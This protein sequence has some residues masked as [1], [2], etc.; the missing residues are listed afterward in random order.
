M[1]MRLNQVLR[2]AAGSGAL[3]NGW[4]AGVMPVFDVTVTYETSLRKLRVSFGSLQT[5]SFRIAFIGAVHPA[6]GELR[7]IIGLRKIDDTPGV[8]LPTG[9]TYG[10]DAATK[11][12]RWSTLYAQP[13]DQLP[14]AAFKQGVVFPLACD[15]GADVR[16]IQIKTDLS[17]GESAMNSIGGGYAEA[18]NVML[19][20][21]SH[22]GKDPDAASSLVATHSPLVEVNVP[23]IHSIRVTIVDSAGALLD[24]NGGS[25]QVSFRFQ[26]VYSGIYQKPEYSREDHELKNSENLQLIS[27]RKAQEEEYQKRLKKKKNK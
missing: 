27:M 13:D 9:S 26:W 5:P 7:E 8:W 3:A 12:N 6:K 10:L 19:A 23:S 11:Q 14:S 1:Q 15:I 21:A 25:F 2:V 22:G 18:S 24:L 17:A 20:C 16:S 4:P